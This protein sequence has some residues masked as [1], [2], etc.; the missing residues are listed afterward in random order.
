MRVKDA[1]SQSFIVQRISGLHP[2]KYEEHDV[3]NRLF[4]LE[5]ALQL[6]CDEYIPLIS[7]YKQKQVCS[8]LIFKHASDLRNFE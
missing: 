4:R 6:E 5:F 2:G 1:M 8:Y 7:L 3:Q